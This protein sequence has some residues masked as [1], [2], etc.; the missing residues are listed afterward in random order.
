[1]NSVNGGSKYKGTYV[2]FDVAIGLCRKYGL[3]ELESQI[4]GVCLN[5]QILRKILASEGIDVEGQPS[6]IASQIST[7]SR[8]DSALPQ[9]RREG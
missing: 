1:M 5:R 7:L 4:R 6:D 2:C 3:V 8:P 9:E